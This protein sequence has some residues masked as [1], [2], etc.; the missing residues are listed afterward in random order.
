MPEE[1]SPHPRVACY[2]VTSASAN[3][4]AKLALGLADN[5]ALGTV[6]EALGGG[7][8]PIVVFPRINAWHA[9]QPARPSHL[10]ALRNA[11][12]HLNLRG[13]CLAAIRTAV[14]PRPRVAL[15]RD[16]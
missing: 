7:I 13:R 11:G 6:C 10:E 2:V 1:S 14:R 4:V 5:Q 15:D 9:G 12:V 16:P 8:V 3:T